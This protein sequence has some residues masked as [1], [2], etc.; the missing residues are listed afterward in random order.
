M[1][2]VGGSFFC[3]VNN[4]STLE[5]CPIE[6]GGSFNCGYNGLSTLVGCP[7]KVGAAFFCHSNALT[8]LE[9]LPIITESAFLVSMGNK[10]SEAECFLYNYSGEQVRHYYANKRISINM[11]NELEKLVG[12]EIKR[13]KI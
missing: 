1:S 10:L 5:Y 11:N 8:S 9:F 4:L 3:H 6:V 12:L 13:L 2:S 7:I